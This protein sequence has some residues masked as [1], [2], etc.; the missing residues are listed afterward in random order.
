M[1]CDVHRKHSVFNYISENSSTQGSEKGRGG[2]R[3]CELKAYPSPA[4]QFEPG[5]S[6]PFL[7]QLPSH[8]AQEQNC[9]LPLTRSREGRQR[10]LPDPC[11]TL[12]RAAEIRAMS[13][14]EPCRQ[15]P[16]IETWRRVPRSFFSLNW[17]WGG[18][19]TGDGGTDFSSV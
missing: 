13:G 9:L 14:Q 1:T 18:G 12:I 11:P 3:G 10:Q 15:S 17:G 4:S 7:L 5:N 8:W 6:R 19:V 16:S 2:G